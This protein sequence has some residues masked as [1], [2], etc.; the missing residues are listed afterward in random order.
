MLEPMPQNIVY[1]YG[2]YQPL[3]N[4][5]Q[6]VNFEEGLPSNLNSLRNT[7]IIIDDLMAELAND[8]RLSNLF[9]KCSHHQNLSVIFVTQNIFIQGKEMRNVNLNSQYIFLFKNPRDKTQAIHLGRQMFPGKVK[10]FQEI[11]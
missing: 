10:A 3:F 6:N 8:L 7:L 11:F 5:M 2:K 1:C 4:S 9:T